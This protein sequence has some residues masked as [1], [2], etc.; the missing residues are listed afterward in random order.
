MSPIVSLSGLMIMGMK[1]CA[2]VKAALPPFFLSGVDETHLSA[3]RLDACFCC[4]SR[5]TFSGPFLFEP[6]SNKETT[7]EVQKVA[8]MFDAYTGPGVSH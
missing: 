8:L 6:G 5:A 7:N 3:R 1:V 4:F 2:R